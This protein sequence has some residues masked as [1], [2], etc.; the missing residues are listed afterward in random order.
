MTDRWTTAEM[1]E[2]A[3]RGLGRIDRWGLRGVTG[4][5]IDEIEAMAEALVLFG[6]IPI[7]PG[8]PAPEH[9][10]NPV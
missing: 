7:P 5:S 3:A 10:V 1:L 9:L 4:L 2:L 6:L 8:S